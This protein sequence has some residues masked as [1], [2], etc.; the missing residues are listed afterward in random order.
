MSNKKAAKLHLRVCAAATFVATYG[1]LGTAAK[2][3]TITQTLT[4]PAVSPP[5]TAAE[6]PTVPF[7]QFNPAFGTLDSVDVTLT[8][9][10]NWS[11]A[12]GGGGLGVGLEYGNGIQVFPPQLFLASSQGPI[13]IDLM[14]TD[15]V[16]F[17]LV[18]GTRTTTFDLVLDSHFFGLLGQT[19]STP[20]LSGSVTYDFAPAA[21]TPLP[22]TL[23]LFASGLGALGL[24]GWRRKRKSR[25]GVA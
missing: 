3:A 11:N 19:F 25:A 21:A 12:P 6:Y 2:A 20:G 18:E 13:S 7:N 24:L 16:N 8:G 4:L 5:S 15:S 10:A 22:A 23:P 14:G 17:A 1:L 9:N